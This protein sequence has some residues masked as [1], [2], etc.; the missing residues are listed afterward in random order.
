MSKNRVQGRLAPDKR[1]RFFDLLFLM[2]IGVLLGF[3]VFS[4][5]LHTGG[6]AQSQTTSLVQMF[7]VIAIMRILLSNKYLIGLSVSLLTLG[8]LGLAFGFL[9]TP[10][11]PQFVNEA[12][13]F[14]TAVI[15][16]VGGYGY[17]NTLY[18]RTFTWFLCSLIGL[19][20]VWFFHVRPSFFVIF[21]VCAAAFGALIFF[22]RLSYFLPFYIFISCSL[23]FLI[24]QLSFT[25][26]KQTGRNTS[27]LR[28]ALPLAL[29]CAVLAAFI[30]VPPEDAR[31]H[32]VQVDFADSLRRLG[33]RPF[34][35]RHP[36]YFAIQQTGFGGSDSRRLGGDVSINDR[37]FMRIRTNA[38][39]PIYLTGATMDTYTGYGWENRLTE[40]APLDFDALAPNLASYEYFTA[41]VYH[42]GTD[43]D[44]IFT[45]DINQTHRKQTI[46]IGGI[47]RRLHTVFHTGLV[48]DFYAHGTELTLL[49]EQSGQLVTQEL[50]PRHTWYTL[51][52]LLPLESSTRYRRD[53]S[54][55]DDS[56][57]HYAFRGFFR[58]NDSC[59]GILQEISTR[60]DTYH[61]SEPA[62]IYCEWDMEFI[63]QDHLF[64]AFTL[65]HDGQEMDF[66]FILQ[67]YLIPRA[68]WIHETYTALP[69]EFP[70]RIGE[71]A[72]A[73]TEGAEG[74][75]H[76]ARLL[77]TYLRTEFVY[78]LTPGTPPPD[79]D[80]V[81]YFLFD[82]RIGYCTYFASAFVTMARSLG[83]PA[84]YVEGFLVSGTPDEDGFIHVLNSMGHA[85]A[86]VYLEGY[87]WL[88][89]EPT[90]PGATPLIPPADDP[91]IHEEPPV[92]E[93]DDPPPTMEP[94]DLPPQSEPQAPN[95]AD[96]TGTVEELPPTRSWVLP[97]SV[98]AFLVLLL[99]LRVIWVNTRE[100]QVARRDN[101]EAVY[102][103]FSVLLRHLK[104]LRLEMKPTETV[105][106]FYDRTAEA[107]GSFSEL[108]FSRELA[109]IYAKARYGDEPIS[110]EERAQME[111]EV[112]RMT[113]VIQN[114][115][116]KWRYLLYKYI[117]PRR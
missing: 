27:F 115:V 57:R 76:R 16:Y 72:R 86:E 28:L 113:A 75:Y 111:H 90:P 66:R 10:D 107:L 52:Y 41:W 102:Y 70:A 110:P 63:L 98:I 114:H 67:N 17:H 99:T 100:A 35:D 54:P 95:V 34:F 116:G 56:E 79:R 97:V 22:D 84:R 71:H 73:L 105:F 44:S 38:A 93:P 89:F 94:P 39:R 60:F 96:P 33:N 21:A 91:D 25:H 80:F 58:R 2:T 45:F 65:I 26:A 108:L 30:P 88:R 64:P 53:G 112:R 40:Q 8:L 62:S 15:Y 85:W 42:M 117:L 92:E 109:E 55:W 69:D 61:V 9:S 101:R 82:S 103:Y 12:A 3:S 18:E 48:Q 43:T 78:T 46:L 24:K 59:Q 50:M 23:V 74:N 37:L 51:T 4:A 1:R 49:Q 7:V 83:I 32:T 20:I 13:D 11:E 81:D 6:F 47:D 5:V 29:V 36:H 104:L 77:E 19:F 14:V 31:H 106:E 87:G 68:E